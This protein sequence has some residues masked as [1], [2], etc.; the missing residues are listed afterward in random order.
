MSTDLNI[1]LSEQAFVGLQQAAIA[2][3]LTPNDLASAALEHQFGTPR[4][5]AANRSTDD[6]RQRFERHFGSL[7][8]GHAVGTDN[9]QIDADLARAYEREMNGR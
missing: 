8:L 9:D 2:T 4:V 1:H 5:D 6:A 3:G 7:D